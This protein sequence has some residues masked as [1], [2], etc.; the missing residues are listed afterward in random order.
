MSSMLGSEMEPGESFEWASEGERDRG[1]LDGRRFRV[2]PFVFIVLAMELR[3]RL[4][5][6]L[7]WGDF[8]TIG[9]SERAS[10]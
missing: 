1:V 6:G 7:A 2:A 4:R 10:E 9:G 5:F 8:L 3:I